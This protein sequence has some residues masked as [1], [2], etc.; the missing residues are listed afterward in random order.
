MKPFDEPVTLRATDFGFS[1]LDV[2]E[3]KEELIRVVVGPSA[4][5]AAIVGENGLDLELVF[6]WR[7]PSKLESLKC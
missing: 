2:F 3:L 1:M 4:E 5:L 7:C 6:L